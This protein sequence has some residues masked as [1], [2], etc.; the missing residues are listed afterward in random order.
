MAKTE[1]SCNTI[2]KDILE[3][4]IVASENS[5]S[6]IKIIIDA[7]QKCEKVVL[8]CLNDWHQTGVF[9]YLSCLYGALSQELPKNNFFRAVGVFR[10][11]ID[12]CSRQTVGLVI[13]LSEKCYRLADSDLTSGLALE[14]IESYLSRYPEDIDNAIVHCEHKDQYGN[15]SQHVWIVALAYNSDLYWKRF[16]SWVDVATK[17]DEIAAAMR[18]LA[19][20]P[21][22]VGGVTSGAADVVE[23]IVKAHGMRLNENGKGALYLAAETWRKVVDCQHR[24]A[25]EK[26][27][28]NLLNE[29]CPFVLYVATREAWL[30]TKQQSIECVDV[31]L[32]AF[33][34]VDPKHKGIVGYLSY[35]L[36]KLM[37]ACPDK[38]FAF[39]ENY[40]REHSCGITVF[41]EIISRM[42]NSDETLRNKYF[43]RWLASDSVS[44]AKNV[45]EIVSHVRPDTTLHINVVFDQS[46][47]YTDD[48]LLLLFLRAIGWLYSIPE[49]CI[50]FLISCACKMGAVECLKSVYDDFFYLVVLNYINE[51]KR[52]L[53]QIPVCD[54]HAPCYEYLRELAI[55]ADKWWERLKTAGVC[56]E[57]SPSIRHKELY[58]KHRSEVYGKAMKEARDNSILSKIAHNICILHGRGWIVP[59]HSEG[60]EKMEESLLKQFSASIRVSQLSEIEDHTLETRLFE[61]RCFRLEGCQ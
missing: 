28:N 8:E 20:I 54:R 15:G 3:R 35:Y 30:S 26:I 27:A 22:K 2:S 38:V 45:Y 24:E 53:G 14:K 46:T 44:V 36:Q 34:K 50:G 61:L 33:V 10:D 55:D 51:Y 48:E 39:V 4:Q 47:K 23:R 60:R 58:A 37:D 1:D 52:L 25:L 41:N 57:L 18:T 59:V 21:E 49:T 11:Y 56:P 17:D 9:D 19:Q 5:V 12:I 16:L 40:S 31:W 29:G 42:A 7:F 6:Q 43:T 32:S 13:D